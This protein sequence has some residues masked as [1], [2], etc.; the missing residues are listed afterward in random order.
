VLKPKRQTLAKK[1]ISLKVYQE[2]NRM[3]GIERAWGLSRPTFSRWRF[4]HITRLPPLRSSVLPAQADE[5][6]ELD[7]LWVFVGHKG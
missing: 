2:R 6:P 4:E 1:A 5:V 3:R 7:E